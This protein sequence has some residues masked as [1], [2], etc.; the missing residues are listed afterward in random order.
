MT[1]A[2]AVA[3]IAPALSAPAQSA[4]AATVAPRSGGVGD[5][6]LDVVMLVDESG[7]ETDANVAAE[8]QTAGTIAQA[9]LN[10]RSRVTV[11][12]FGGVN[13]VAPDQV[14]V[15]VACQPTIASGTVDLGYL[16][17]CVNSLHRRTEAEGDDTDYAAALGQAMS[18]FNPNSAYGRQSPA[19]AIKVILMMT[20]GGVDVHRDTQQYGDDWLAG[21]HAAVNQQLALAQAYH[22]Q[23]WPLGFGTI[24]STDQQYLDYLA[25]SGYQTA[26]DNRPVSKPRAQ[27]V[28]SAAYA[29][30][31]LDTLYASAA[32]IG[33]KTQTGT[34]GGANPTRDL[35]LS[36]PPIAS[37]AA[38]SVDRGNTGVQVSFYKPGNVQW[39]DGSAI[40]GTQTAVETLHLPNPEPGQWR[41]HLTAPKGAASELVSATVFWQG[42]VDALITATPSSAQPGQRINVTLTVLGSDG[43]PVTD[44][45]E[46]SQM[47]VAVSAKGD[48]LSGPTEIPVSNAG[49][50]AGSAT[51]LGGYTGA[52]TAPRRNGTLTF[53]GTAAGYGLY[54]TRIPATVQVGSGTPAFRSTVTLPS[55][56]TVQAGKSIQ[57][58][59]AFANTSG[60]DHSVRLSLSI[61]PAYATITPVGSIQVPSG[62][63][64]A[65]PFTIAFAKNSPTGTAFLEVKVVDA[66]N[67]STVYSAGTLELTVT[68]PP[69][70]VDQYLWAF[71]GVII[72]AI[73][74]VL[75]LFLRARRRKKGSDVRGLYAIIRRDGEQLGADLKAPNKQADTFRFVIRDETQPEARLDYPSRSDDQPYLVQ[76][77]RPGQVNVLTP[78]RER[79]EVSIGGSGEPLPSGLQ[80]AFRDVRRSRPASS[81]GSRRQTPPSGGS[82]PAAPPAD[83]PENQWL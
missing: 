58:Q 3:G 33:S 71:I 34:V 40:S 66:A 8:R 10:P 82:G 60:T 12:G 64:P 18:Y 23:I 21:E 2:F 48:G 15:N 37:D 45:S 11:V 13:N 5:A 24:S 44:P 61:S 43:R 74:V 56:S 1:T 59:V 35:Y 49:E 53:T 80:L 57:G 9:L 76:R 30:A 41:I 7:S 42:A 70:L 73:L 4:W 63:P 25:A 79:Y 54:A 26:C 65:T 31:A 72:L 19:G 38:I 36:I 29:L 68:A 77:G 39:T 78:L 50:T 22:V 51:G 17:S 14:P 28:Q 6:V 67:P 52:F 55:I 27:V 69:S 32:C 47:Q 16:A 62:S 81:N 83:P 75:L 20:D 46:L